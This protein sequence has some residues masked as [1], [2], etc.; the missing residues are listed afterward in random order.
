MFALTV[1]HISLG[2]WLGAV[3]F[4][5]A[6]VAPAVFGKLDATGAR[7]VL[8]ALFPRFF[9]LGITC[10]AAALV[11]ALLLPAPTGNRLLAG[12]ILLSALAMIIV[13]RGIVPAINRASDAGDAGRRRFG[14]LHGLSVLLTLGSLLAGL[15]VIVLLNRG[16]AAAAA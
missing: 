3:V 16:F 11:A 6:L 7:D 5:S 13:A 1:L 2:V 12:W 10:I 8:R 14:Q 15:V 4:Q 9:V